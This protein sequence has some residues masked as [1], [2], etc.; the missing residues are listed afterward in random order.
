MVEVVRRAFALCGPVIIMNC[1]WAKWKVRSE[2]EWKLGDKMREEWKQRSDRCGS[3]DELFWLTL[4]LFLVKR[5]YSR[6]MLIED[7][8]GFWQNNMFVYWKIALFQS[9]HL[10]FSA[11]SRVTAQRWSRDVMG[12]FASFEFWK[13]GKRMGQEKDEEERGK[14]EKWYPNSEMSFV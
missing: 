13:K 9:E 1:D 8:I 3:I 12:G 5:K 11:S 6:V 2:N 14:E 4:K 10:H 7:R